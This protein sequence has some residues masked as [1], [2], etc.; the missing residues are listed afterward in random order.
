MKDPWKDLPKEVDQIWA[1]A[2]QRWR[3]RE[4]LYLD[5]ELELQA[6]S[7]QEEH[8]EVQA[9]DRAGM[10]EAF[11]RKEIPTTWES[12]TMRQRQDWFK[13]ASETEATEPRM[14]RETICAVE[15]LVELFGQQLD[16]RTRYRSREINQILRELPDL[17]YAGRGYD[18]VYGRQH[19][20]TIKDPE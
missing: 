5:H 19:R 14:R 4:P 15:I 11:V 12:M 20:Y 3:E 8:N 7:L 17:E 1:E 13:L 18:K 10:I 2:M 6:R 9:D 16:E